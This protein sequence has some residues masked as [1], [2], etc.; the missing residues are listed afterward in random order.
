[1]SRTLSQF[2][3]YALISAMVV[4]DDADDLFRPANDY[5]YS[6]ESVFCGRQSCKSR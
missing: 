5:P 4:D 3:R 6:L 1:M 2:D